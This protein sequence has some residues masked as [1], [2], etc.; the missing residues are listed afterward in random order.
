MGLLKTLAIIVIVYYVLKFVSRFILPLFVQKIV[1]DVQKKYTEQQQH[2]DTSGKVGETV[3]S[4][5]PNEPK[6]N[7]EVGDYVDYEE[8]KD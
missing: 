5:R 8:I 2:Y 4:K 7:K 3:I 1:K 6:S